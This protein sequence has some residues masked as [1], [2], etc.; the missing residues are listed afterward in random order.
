[1]S[2]NDSIKK[3]GS[4]NDNEKPLTAVNSALYSKMEQGGLKYIK[5]QRNYILLSALVPILSIAVQIVNVSMILVFSLGFLDY[6][7]PPLGERPPIGGLY[8]FDVLSPIL[9]VF[10]FFIIAMIHFIYLYRWKKR[11]YRYENQEKIVLKATTDENRITLTQ[12]FY[13]ILDN[14]ETIRK[15]FIAL[16]II[17]IFYLQWFFRF[18]LKELFFIISPRSDLNPLRFIIPTINLGLQLLLI[19]YLIVSWKHFIKWN[20]KLNKIK[21][22]EQQIYE[23]I[24]MDSQL[25]VIYGDQEELEEVQELIAQQDRNFQLKVVPIPSDEIFTQKLEKIIKDS[26]E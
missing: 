21:T 17:S 9:I 12:L 16:N 25:L 14:M 22:L 3:T 5:N 15:I 6:A 24:N 18:F 23:E 1:M 13:D 8:L 7:K 11:V 10:I 26:E 2:K 19:I 20:S 4:V